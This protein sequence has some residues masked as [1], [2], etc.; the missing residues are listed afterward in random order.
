MVEEIITLENDDVRVQVM[1]HHGG[2]I[3]HLINQ[4]DEREWLI[5]P[6]AVDT[7]P[8]RLDD[9]YTDTNHFGWD[10]MLPTIDS[11]QYPGEPYSDLA[12]A[13]HGELW[14]ALWEVIDRGPTSLHQRVEGQRMKYVF[15]RVLELRGAV[16]RCEYRC[17]TPVDTAMLWALHPQFVTRDATR[18]QLHP[19]PVSVLDTSRATPRVRDWPGDLIVERDIVA[20]SDL[21]I[22]VD[23]MVAVESASLLDADGS[24][25]TMTWDWRFARYLGIWADHGRHSGGRVIAIEPTNS[26]YDDL[27]KAVAHRRSTPFAANQP[28]TWWVEI[29]LQSAKVAAP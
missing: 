14:T 2:R 4:R 17:V 21:M 29:A 1:A 13:D 11:C 5:G 6:R 28:L 9:V 19:E 27:S 25:L 10:E 3:T 15:D 12:L 26:F 7:T 23:P 24:S 16:L 8:P 22:Y 20:G 18:L